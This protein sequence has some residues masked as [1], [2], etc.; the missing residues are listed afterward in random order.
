MLE[1]TNL[2]NS[3][4]EQCQHGK[5]TRVHFKTKQHSSTKPLELVH[6]DLC[7]P[8]KSKGLNGEKYFMLLI[9]D[10]TRMIWVCILNGKSKYFGDFKTFKELVENETGSRIKCPGSD[11]GG[12]FTSDE[13]NKYCEEHVIKRQ[14]SVARTPHQNGVDE[15]K[16]N[17]VME[18]ARTMLNESKLNDKFW[19]H[20]IHIA[21][22][23]LNR[24]LLKSKRIKLPTSYGQEERQM[25][26]TS[27]FLEA[28][29]ISKEKIRRLKNLTLK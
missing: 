28:S 14:F 13:F 29:A 6:T 8:T 24:G 2:A 22:H 16:N 11:N 27:N 9:D 7:G 15:R 4:C 12:E 18:M 23:I 1:V 5:Q 19:G 21:V 25:Y 26:D 10:Y 17:I 3:I 20:A